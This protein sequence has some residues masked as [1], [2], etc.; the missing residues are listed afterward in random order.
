MLFKSIVALLV[1]GAQL[2]AAAPYD[3]P[4]PVTYHGVLFPSP[5]VS[6]VADLRRNVLSRNK[7]A[8]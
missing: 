8:S 5:T 2:V 4:D 7:F 6:A 1:I 3:P